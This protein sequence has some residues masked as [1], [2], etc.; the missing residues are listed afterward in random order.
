[1]QYHQNQTQMS[2]MPSKMVSHASLEQENPTL[3]LISGA[4]R[5]ALPKLEVSSK[6]LPA[7]C[8]TSQRR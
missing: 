5:D 8:R 4:L 2:L 3:R 6:T 7:P 1:M